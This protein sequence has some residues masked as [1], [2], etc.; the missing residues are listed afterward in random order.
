MFLWQI[1]Q[2]FDI[3]RNILTKKLILHL[4]TRMSA[5]SKLLYIFGLLEFT[6]S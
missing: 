2:K 3:V 4:I 6:T 5:T 1:S